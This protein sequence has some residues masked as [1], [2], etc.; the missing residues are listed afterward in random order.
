MLISNSDGKIKWDDGPWCS[1]R[2]EALASAPVY[3]TT[4]SASDVYTVD[5]FETIEVIPD[6]EV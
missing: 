2:E 3:E 4:D 6:E 5:A 1:T